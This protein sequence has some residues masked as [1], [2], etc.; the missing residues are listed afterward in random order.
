MAPEHRGKGVAAPG[1]A[2]VLRYALTEIAPVASLYVNDFNTP[3][4]R[5]YEKVGF[6]EVGAFMSVLF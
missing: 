3:A 1:M 4:R 6:Q 5:T 2:A